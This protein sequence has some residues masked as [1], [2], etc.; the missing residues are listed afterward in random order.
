[1]TRTT[2]PEPDSISR[3]TLLGTAA[4]GGAALAA[5]ILAAPGSIAAAPRGK[6]GQIA[7][8]IGA[9]ELAVFDELLGIAQEVEVVEAQDGGASGPAFTRRRPGRQKLTDVTL[10]RPLSDDLTVAAW[11]QEV[12]SG[13]IS[14]FRNVTLTAYDRINKPIARYTLVN[15]WPLKVDVGALT[16]E[17]GMYETVTLTCE[18]IL[19]IAV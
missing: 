18:A 14:A 11:Y 2:D 13:E 19:R 15:A 12:L 8:T 1:M 7:L 5:G 17:Q 3:R 6:N 10:R 16:D 4:A 9:D